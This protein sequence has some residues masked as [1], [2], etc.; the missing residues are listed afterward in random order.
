MQ[1][2]QDKYIMLPYPY[3]IIASIVA[4]NITAFTILL[5]I[6]WMIFHSLIGKIIAWVITVIAWVFVYIYRNK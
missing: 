1:L 5:Q 6:D 4:V 2:F 3:F